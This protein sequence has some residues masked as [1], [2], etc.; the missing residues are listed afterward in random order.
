MLNALIFFQACGT[1]NWPGWNGKIDWTSSR[2]ENQSLSVS[3]KE[4]IKQCDNLKRKIE[5]REK[6]KGNLNYDVESDPE[7][8]QL[9]REAFIS[10]SRYET[11][12]PPITLETQP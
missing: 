6:K 9:D 2:K 10:S 8:R 11:L 1:Q 7:F 3:M 5:K 12:F 4:V